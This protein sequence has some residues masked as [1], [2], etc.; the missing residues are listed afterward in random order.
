MLL[1]ISDIIRGHHRRT[2]W[3]VLLFV[4]VAGVVGGPVAG[5][6]QSSANSAPTGTDSQRAD[7]LLERA[8]GAQ[9]S[10]N[11]VL[12]VRTPPGNPGGRA[13]GAR[14]RPPAWAGARRT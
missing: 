7:Q 9:A 12:L 8:T 11:V 6:L 4:V 14:D 3:L 10:A 1:K 2:L 13:T 5:S